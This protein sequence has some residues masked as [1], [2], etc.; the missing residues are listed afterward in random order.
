[1]W[2][3]AATWLLEFAFS[4]KKEKTKQTRVVSHRAFEVLLVPSLRVLLAL[5]FQDRGR[6]SAGISTAIDLPVTD[7]PM[8][9]VHVINTTRN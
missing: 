7:M 6:I 8:R 5:A 2:K 9:I 4:L 3:H 1:M